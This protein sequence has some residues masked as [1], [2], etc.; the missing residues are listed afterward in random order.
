MNQHEIDHKILARLE[1]IKSVSPRDSNSAMRG[2]KDFLNEALQLEATVS[3]HGFLRHIKWI[4]FGKEKLVMNTVISMIV[5]ATLLFGGGATVNAA[6]DDL[7]GE[8]LYAVKTASEDVSVQFTGNAEAKVVRLMELARIRTQEMAQLIEEGKTPPDQVRQRLE[9]H[10]QSVFQICANMDDATLDR[11]LLH[12]RDQLRDRDR[13]MERLQI[14][15]TSDAQR[16]LEQTRLMLQIRLHTVEDGLLN[17]EQFRQTIRNQHRNGQDDGLTPPAVTGTPGHDQNQEQ[18]TEQ[19]REQNGQPSSVPGGND[20]PG[21][22]NDSPGG[23]NDNPGGPN[24]NPGG[25]NDQA[26]PGPNN[27]NGSGSG[28]ST[29]PG[30]GTGTGGTDTGSNGTGGNKP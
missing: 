21:G 9:Q 13:D 22:P 30:S 1:E 12:L 27:D 8:T 29:G 7:P 4:P 5:V 28:T 19:N 18:N 16:L 14:H 6:Q 11:T 17:H 10:L 20:N 23:P 2:R 26:T 3:G 15:A 24:D 25:P